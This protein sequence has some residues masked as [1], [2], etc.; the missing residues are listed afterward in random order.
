[1][2][3]IPN[4]F[5]QPGPVADIGSLKAWAPK[6]GQTAL[7]DAVLPGH[8][9]A[10]ASGGKKDATTVGKYHKG[11]AV[12]TVAK[13]RLMY[14]ASIGGQSLNTL[15]NDNAYVCRDLRAAPAP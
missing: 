14:E 9:S 4:V 7:R 10:G 8:N 13:G 12:F 15:P 5:T 11:M 3:K 6:S 1:M 2:V